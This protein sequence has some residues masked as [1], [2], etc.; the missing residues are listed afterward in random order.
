L[1]KGG[2][3]FLNAKLHKAYIIPKL[4]QFFMK[5]DQGRKQVIEDLNSNQGLGL[6]TVKTQ[7][8]MFGQD[9]IILL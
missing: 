5:I 8:R 3:T 2:I 9:L 6:R 7:P 4:Q 1:L